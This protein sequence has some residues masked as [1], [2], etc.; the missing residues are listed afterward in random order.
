[1][2]IGRAVP[3]LIATATLCGC[4]TVNKMAV[5][6]VASTLSEGGDTVTS[7]DD[8]DLI[9]GA[10]PFALML[11][12]SLLASVP[13]YEPLLTTTCGLFT[14]YAFGFI[15]ADAE[16]LQRD[17]YDR[18]KQLADRA[19]RLAE[20]GRKYCWRGL[21]SKFRGISE[22]LKADPARALQRAKKEHV[23]L[24]YWSAAALG[25]A[26]STGGIEHPELLIDWPVVRALA[27]RALVLDETW[28]NGSIPELM[29]TVESQGDALGGSEE[30]ARR[31]FARAVEIQQGLSPGP[32][33]ALATGVIKSNQDRGEFTKLLGQALAIDPERDPTHRLV[34]LV[35]QKRARL[36][37]ERIDDLFLE[38][39]P[40]P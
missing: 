6:G 17:N 7:H 35:T 5:K 38:P 2:F 9:A 22:A 18:S 39:A 36:L 33:V 1:M 10:M 25:A 16:A 24:L 3:L 11:H 19:F 4:A 40:R 28:N 20:R 14:Q 30:R 29:V 8:P 32:Y 13:T 15:A 37:L 26:I 21:E 31:H 34:T 27:E 12:E 23:E